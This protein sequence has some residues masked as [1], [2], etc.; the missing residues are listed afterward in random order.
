MN[1][2]S[3]P[4]S[5]YFK[6]ILAARQA[7]IDAHTA[8][9]ESEGFKSAIARVD[10][11]IADY[12]IAINAIDFAA[13]RHPPFFET[14]MTLRLK[15]QFVESM[16]ATA[17][18]IKE[19]HHNPA[20]RELRFLLEASIK[21]LWLDSGCPPIGLPDQDS[22]KFRAAN[23][24]AKVASLDDLGRERFGEVIGSLKFKLMDEAGA[25]AYR[26]VANSLYTSLSTHV[27]ISSRVIAR[28]LK[29]FDRDRY[30][31]FETIGD[32]NKI[33]DLMRQ[34]LDLA[35]KRIPVILKHSLH[36]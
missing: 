3:N 32:V 21:T 30:F 36:A 34:V 10:R 9:R 23:V 27:H 28:D 1:D 16:V 29:A 33:V 35:L 20:R 22:A 8:L 12:G 17:Q 7:R 13:T 19:G 15:Q 31:G 4:L 2:A 25:S 6:D 26:Q 11:L 14:L 5:N 24:D 18:A